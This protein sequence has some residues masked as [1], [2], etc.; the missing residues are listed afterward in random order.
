MTERLYYRNAY[1][2]DFDAVVVSCVKN[3]D[4][5]EIILDRTLFYPEGGGQRI[6]EQ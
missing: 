5:Y 3:N 2:S 1:D 4:R 6:M